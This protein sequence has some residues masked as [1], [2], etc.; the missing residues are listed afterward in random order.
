MTVIRFCVNTECHELKKLLM[1]YWE[2]ILSPTRFVSHFTFHDDKYQS[3]NVRIDFN[4]KIAPKY[5][6]SKKLLPEMI[7]VCNALLKDLHHS[8]EFV[9]GSML[10]FLCKVVLMFQFFS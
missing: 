2:V 6:D 8:N 9:R 5:D 4:F 10:R 7:L 1:I 3:L